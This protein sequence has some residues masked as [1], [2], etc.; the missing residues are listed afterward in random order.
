MKFKIIK[1]EME[2]MKITNKKIDQELVYKIKMVKEQKRKV[3]FDKNGNVKL[4][5][6]PPC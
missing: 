5:N 3:V 6:V 4:V 2:Y 1:S